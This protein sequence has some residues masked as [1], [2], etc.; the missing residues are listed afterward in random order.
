[1]G[2]LDSG[3]VGACGGFGE[4]E[5]AEDF[6]GG[7][8]LQIF[9]FVRFAAEL[10]E[11]RLNRRVGY[12]ERGGHGG[13]DAGDFFEHQHVGNRVQAGAAPLVG[14]EHATAAHFAES[15]QQV[16]GEFFFAFEVLDEG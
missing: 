2:G 8:A 4:A 6:A 10:R 3:G 1:G 5:G 12:A 7:E 13:V 9:L 14:R 15:F 16:E 11:R